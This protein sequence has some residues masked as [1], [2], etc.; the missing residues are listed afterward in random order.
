MTTCAS[1]EF[2]K[3]SK[4]LEKLLQYR[5]IV[6]QRY[7]EVLKLDVRAMLTKHKVEMA[8]AVCTPK[9]EWVQERSVLKTEIDSWKERCRLLSSRINELRQNI[10]V[11]SVK[12]PETPQG[13]T[14]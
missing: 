8:E 12:L 14:E 1:A 13:G 2:I 4:D 9:L 7:V 3:F 5:G 10:E 11:M 6:R